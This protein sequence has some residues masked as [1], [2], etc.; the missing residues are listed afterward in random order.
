MIDCRL[1]REGAALSVDKAYRIQLT[2][3]ELASEAVGKNL[4]RQSQRRIVHN[5]CPVA[6]GDELLR[7]HWF[8]VL[9][10]ANEES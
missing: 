7:A 10:H 6:G 5:L 2:D 1:C 3:G 8:V 4:E 9:R